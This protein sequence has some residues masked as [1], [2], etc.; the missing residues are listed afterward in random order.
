MP[1]KK[2]RRLCLTC[3][4]LFITFRLYKQSGTKTLAASAS[5]TPN[6]PS[7]IVLG[8]T[9]SFKGSSALY[10]P[11][12]LRFSV[13]RVTGG[14]SVSLVDLL[15]TWISIQ[16]VSILSGPIFSHLTPE[17]WGDN[18][19][20]YLCLPRWFCC[21]S[22]LYVFL[23]V[24]ACSSHSYSLACSRFSYEKGS[25]TRFNTA[26]WISMFF[27]C[28]LAKHAGHFSSV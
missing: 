8:A 23:Y 2:V 22:V 21:S 10:I 15:K 26:H 20:Y 18:S 4:K 11:R 27:S 28:I 16:S 17:V 3:S 9:I 5:A 19:P 7:L 24:F 6:P 13:P 1:Q 12:T 25:V 14:V